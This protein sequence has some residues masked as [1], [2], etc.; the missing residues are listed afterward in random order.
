MSLSRFRPTA[1]LLLAALSLGIDAPA[2]HAS[3]LSA[4]EQRL[5]G[6]LDGSRALHDLRRLSQDIIRTPSGLGAGTVV[7][8]SPEE[9]VL[10]REIAKTL[11]ATGMQVRLE[12]YPVRAYGYGPVALTA[13]GASVRAI[14]L[15][16]T[17]AVLGHRDGVMFAHGNQSSG[18]RLAARLVDAGS[19][20]ADDYA[21]IGDVRG[22]IVLVRRELRDWPPPQIT[23][24]ASHGALA[25]VFYGHPGSDKQPDALRQDS[26]WGHE[27][28]PAAAISQRSADALR[29]QLAAGPVEAT[30]E[31]HVEITDGLSRNVIGTIRGSER[32]DEWVVVSAHLDRWFE[33]AADNASGVAAVLEIAR[34]FKRSGLKPRRS[35]LFVAVSSE[36]AGQEDPE[37]DWL[38]GSYA[39]MQRHPELARNAA[40]IFNI[41]LL[42]WTTSKAKL[43]ATADVLG[44][45]TSV[46]HDLGYSDQF[47]T[48]ITAGSVT[49]AWNYGV[50]GGA[51]TAHIESIT[52]DYYP[53][54]H[55]QQDVFRPEMYQNMQ[56]DLRVLTLSLWRAATQRQ[57]PIRLTAVADAVDAGLA[58]DAARVTD[59]SFTAVRAALADFRSAAAAVERSSRD[60]ATRLLMH[61]RHSLVPWLYASNDDFEQVVRTTPYG[62]RV[63]AFERVRAALE[64]ADLSAAK[65][66]LA[67]LYE[68]RQCLQLSAEVYQR[69][70][71][72]W[73]GDGGWASRFQ[74]RTPP[75][76][77]AFE[78]ACGELR[79][80]NSD[81][82]ALATAFTALRNDAATQVGAAS[83]LLTA[84]LRLATDSLREF[85]RPH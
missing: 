61:T 72:F 45:E 22:S 83:E 65:K 16:A 20:Y 59:V 23:E 1:L 8:G 49:D 35:I 21:R 80:A 79:H 38:A 28:I 54:Y 85:S 68:G 2:A 81:R 66:A 19:G 58:A 64:G 44:L 82:A 74:Q 27:Q 40:L 55:T 13:N 17:S 3:D 60:D 11:R 7:S 4:D 76:P 62:N 67:A 24:A 78:A 29:A 33:G 56:T 42:G 37:R 50:V 51:A 26:L 18:H 77:P 46:L 15:H 71:A 6:Q 25:I 43:N 69:E 12:E 30:L 52:P 14:G 32:P 47:D 31:S 34:A 10:A 75:P 84:K 63:V 36:E 48:A 39:L 70:R 41:D 57:L 53:L 73:A 5:L 9:R